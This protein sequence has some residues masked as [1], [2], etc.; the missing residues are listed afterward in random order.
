MESSKCDYQL[1]F[2]TTSSSVNASQ[3]Q[4]S[5]DTHAR[6]RLAATKVAH[7]S[8]S[9]RTWNREKEGRVLTML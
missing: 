1:F 7:H 9:L 4:L 5:F 6:R 2:F 8:A 3:K